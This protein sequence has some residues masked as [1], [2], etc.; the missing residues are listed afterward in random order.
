M[1]ITQLKAFHALAVTGGFTRAAELLHVTQPAVTTQLKS[2]EHD[3]GVELIKRNGH[4]LSLSD[5]GEHLF[6]ITTHLFG[7]LEAA[8]EV[9][10]NASELRGGQLRIAADSPFFIMDLLAN[11]KTL[12]PQMAVTVEMGSASQCQE[13]LRNNTVDVAVLTVVDLPV[14]LHAEPFSR[15]ELMLL[16]RKDHAW[17]DSASIRLRKLK[18]VSM[19][20]REPTSI[21]RDIFVRSMSAVD[22]TP[23]VALE[24]HSQVAV[25]EAVAA[26]L[27]LAV[28]LDGG[29]ANDP[30]LRLI[31]IRDCSIS[32]KEY[33]ACHRNRA[34]LRKII[35]FFEL[36]KVVAPTLPRAERLK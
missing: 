12:Y 33:V 19:I 8:Q 5:I 6:G 3:Y 2:L 36:A 9:L 1:K 14:D 26:G 7:L 24:L 11:Y 30:R 17:A 23:N 20:L 13:W 31:R 29:F 34:T 28:E 22:M 15:L 25:R 4:E 35:S 32:G 10:D 18:D 16:V 27:G 21:T